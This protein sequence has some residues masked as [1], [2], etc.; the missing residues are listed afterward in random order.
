[1]QYTRGVCF[2]HGKRFAESAGCPVKLRAIVYTALR[3][4]VD[5]HID[6]VHGSRWKKTH[7]KRTTQICVYVEIVVWRRHRYYNIYPFD[8]DTK[9][10]NGSG[11]FFIIIYRSN[12]LFKHNN[13]LIVLQRTL[14]AV[15]KTIHCIQC[16][17]M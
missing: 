8:T 15:R 6:S 12:V 4:A 17:I 9:N 13:I 10:G 2:W 5:M 7:K 3:R 16:I 1:M 14:F 11:F